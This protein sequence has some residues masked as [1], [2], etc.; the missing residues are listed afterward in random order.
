MTGPA[1]PIVLVG[2]SGVVSLVLQIVWQRLLVLSTGADVTSVALILAGLMTGLGLGSFAGGRV[3]DA[4]GARWRWWN[5]AACHALLAICAAATVPVFYGGLYET[6]SPAAPA[7]VVAAAAVVA[8][9]VPTIVIGAVLPLA[10]RL[11]D[12]DRSVPA[13]WPSRL[14]GVTSLGGAV[15]AIAAVEWLQPRF[16]IAGAAA[17]AALLSAVGAGIAVAG[18]WRA[19]ASPPAASRGEDEAAP[20][21]RLGGWLGAAALAGF[22]GIGLE[23]VWF[24]VLDVILRSHAATFAHLLAMYLVGYGAGVLTTTASFWR[25][26]SASLFW[27]LQGL[28][29]VYSVACVTLFT[30]LP[31]IMW[32]PDDR[33]WILLARAVA[34][35]ALVTPASL[36]LGVSL[37]CLHRAALRDP[38]GLGRQVGAIQAASIGGAAVGAVVVGFFAFDWI[39]TSGTLGLL[40]VTGVCVAG[41]GLARPARRIRPAVLALAATAAAVL[42]VMPTTTRLW[43]RLSGVGDTAIVVSE[44]AAGVTVLAAE[45]D[46]TVMLRVNGQ[47]QSVLPYGGIHTLLGALP[48]VLHPHPER[49][50]VIGLGSGNTAY[51]A[52]A[53]AETRRVD[54]IEIVTPMRAALQSLQAI[55]PYA[56]LQRLLADPRIHHHAADGRAFLWRSREPYDVIEADALLPDRRLAGHLYSREFFAL[57]RDRLAPGGLSVTWL[58]TPRVLASLRTVFPYVLVIG[59][60]GM[61]SDRPIDLEA[62]AMA[63]R[64]AG[65]AAYFHAAA[66]DIAALLASAFEDGVHTYSPD[67]PLGLDES[68]NEDLFPRDELAGPAP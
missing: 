46:D 16:G 64:I 40:T 4:G 30:A 35:V 33:S 44:G 36:L 58:P 31:D 68:I 1:V 26:R 5:L 63:R 39:G 38:R 12:D 25:W 47:G 13:I 65:T 3:A 2:V 21:P 15:G 22:V 67:R 37:G 34:G 55:W 48:A 27:L 9:I 61:G 52:A 53:R 11:I 18:A 6:L 10:V 59:E 49:V 20:L 56:G 24:R 43:S 19:P 57:V 41:L 8:T 45:T 50:A 60:I 54:V 7:A 62:D 51:A 14:V 17:V 66:V 32:E 23:I 29:P 42:A 28:V